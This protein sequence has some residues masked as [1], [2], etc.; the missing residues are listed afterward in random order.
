MSESTNEN[1]ASEAPP[2]TLL[3]VANEL[4]DALALGGDQ[5]NLTSE[6]S[7][8][9]RD[10]YYQIGYLLSMASRIKVLECSNKVDTMKLMQALTSANEMRTHAVSDAAAQ[11][12]RGAVS[13]MLMSHSKEV[14]YEQF[15]MRLFVLHEGP[16]PLPDN[17]DARAAIKKVLG[18]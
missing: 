11:V 9:L 12:G 7:A 1:S 14:A 2:R 18:S 10:A 15:S 5:F 17:P 3:D 8:A 6:A 16:P 4:E 13:S